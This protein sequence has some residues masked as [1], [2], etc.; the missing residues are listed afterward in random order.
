MYYGDTEENKI[1]VKEMRLVKYAAGIRL[2]PILY[3]ILFE[4]LQSTITMENTE[5]KS[6]LHDTLQC[7]VSARVTKPT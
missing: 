3:Y 1:V 6:V 4:R 2:V 5:M 7:A